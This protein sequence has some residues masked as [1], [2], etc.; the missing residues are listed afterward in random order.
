[1]TYL[2][3]IQAAA[4]SYVLHEAELS[5]SPWVEKLTLVWFFLTHIY[6]FIYLFM[7]MCKCSLW[8]P[9]DPLPLQNGGWVFKYQ[10]AL[11]KKQRPPKNPGKWMK[12]VQKS[13]IIYICVFV[14]VCVCL[15][16]VMSVQISESPVQKNRGPQKPGKV[17]EE[18]SK[19][20]HYICV[21]VCVC[22][23]VCLCI[24]CGCCWA[25]VKYQ[26]KCSKILYILDSLCKYQLLKFI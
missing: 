13:I 12:S 6:L 23:C 14:C 17:D 4:A 25:R 1:M 15:P 11:F 20:H 9:S 2:K 21:F 24:L 10:K 7:S 8:H 22:L 18:C 5:F 16:W 3:Y 26:W 19:I